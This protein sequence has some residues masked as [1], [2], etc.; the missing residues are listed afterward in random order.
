MSKYR[1]LTVWVV[2][3]SAILIVYRLYNRWSGTPQIEPPGQRTGADLPVPEFG[4]DDPSI[5]GARVGSVKNSYFTF[6]DPETKKLKRVLR[7]EKL[8]KP[9]NNS[10][11]W[12]VVKPRMDMYEDKF[13]CRI[14]ADKGLIEVET[15][16]K[17]PNPT[18]AELYE[19]V[20]I[21]IHSTD[22]EKPG[23][24]FIYLDQLTY[25]SDRSEFSTD[26]PIR[27]VSDDAE[28]EGTG[29]IVIYNASLN[30]IEFLKILELDY[31]RLKNVADL[32]SSQEE[33]ASDQPEIAATEAPAEQ[34]DATA[35]TETAVAAEKTG[36]L[37]QCTLTEEVLIR[38]G[39]RM[40]VEAVDQIAI[41]DIL[42]ARTAKKSKEEPS[43]QAEPPAADPDVSTVAVLDD[44]NPDIAP[45]SEPAK[46]SLE[47][48]I[49]CKGAIVAKP[50]E[51]VY[52]NIEP[53]IIGAST[54]DDAKSLAFPKTPTLI[55]ARPPQERYPRSSV[56]F[57]NLAGQPAPAAEDQ[58]AAALAGQIRIKPADRF[59]ARSIA[60]NSSTGA[61]VARGPVEVT[62]H[63]DPNDA[64]DPDNTVLPMIVTAT[65]DAQFF[66]DE[67]RVMER[68]VFNRDVVGTRKSI[69]P[70]YLQTSRFYGD[71]LTIDLDTAKG[72]T[73]GDVKQVSVTDG[74]VG[75]ESIRTAADTVIS[76]TTLSCLRIDYDGKK[77]IVRATGPGIIMLNNE[78]AP[79]PDKDKAQSLSFVRPCYG[80]IRGF[81]KLTWFTKAMQINAD[82]KGE[83]VFMAYWPI[84]DGK[85][86]QII[87]GSATHMQANFMPMPDGTDE[88]ATLITTGGILYEEVG[89]N[90][91]K[92]DDLL[93]DARKSLLTVKGS[94]NFPCLLNR[95][96]VES[97]EYEVDTGNVRSQLAASP[98]VLS[99]PTS[100]N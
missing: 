32:A 40:I 56:T 41:S 45:Q 13:T 67:Q 27:L 57:A 16:N 39:D 55:A 81:D 10:R 22:P 77:E 43:P 17:N 66:A 47:V 19:N 72:V 69:T 28:M 90:I 23:D 87:R 86:G 24:S 62:L 89:T 31:I 37:Y 70:Q 25:N 11:R 51:S 36:D 98:G 35:E 75:L 83:S 80:L 78:N 100:K 97:I 26:G 12:P 99:L 82:G 92:G 5:G 84:V 50:M 4:S 3:V 76:H 30:R 1:V 21:R 74:K 20:V 46:P 42:L 15:V 73:Q 8:L 88:L 95:V 6:R 65:Q 2:A 44:P 33:P 85:R 53:P 59:K 52:D 91:F 61:G 68:I 9:K 29:M 49:T 18:E 38:Y 64:A 58:T 7:F 63:P 79:E 54:P 48:Y 94:E 71:K 93:Y 14:T 34:P 96:L 60:Y